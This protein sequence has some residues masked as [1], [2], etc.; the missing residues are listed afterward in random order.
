MTAKHG[1][2]GE[3]RMEKFVLAFIPLFVAVNVISIIPIFLAL[4]EDI[5]KKERLIAI[6][7][8]IVTAAALTLGFILLG[9]FVF[10]ILGISVGDFMVA[11]GI[12]LFAIAIIDI[13]NPIR[14]KCVPTGELGVVPLGTPL[15]AG[16]A[17]LTTSLMMLE[18]YGMAPTIAAVLCN[19]LIVGV[20]FFFS[21][22]LIKMIGEAGARA[23]SKIASLL[24]AAIA[25]MMI[26]KGIFILFVITG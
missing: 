14:K 10:R 7:Q 23:L 26:R 19:L 17:V 22:V 20:L 5:G 15:I 24:L 21:A 18:A 25:V 12:L 1:G 8:S 3:F 9:K 13:V 16:P 4:T 6:A 2:Q 11:G